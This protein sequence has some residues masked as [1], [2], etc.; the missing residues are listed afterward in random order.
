MAE[1][2]ETLEEFV[3]RFSDEDH[4][5]DKVRKLLAHPDVHGAVAYVC[6]DMCSSH[7]G[8]CKIVVFGEGHTFSTV[9]M[10]LFADF[11]DDKKC[12]RMLD[13]EL[14]ST[15]KLPEYYYVKE[16]VE[17]CESKY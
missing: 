7:M 1:K 9:D 15:I 16:S 5:Q 14:C 4:L 6:Q 10:A 11:K 2:I 17:L 8:E 13:N 12:P 3:S